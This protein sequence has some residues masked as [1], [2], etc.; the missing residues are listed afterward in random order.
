MS[1]TNY[2]SKES[3]TKYYKK[4]KPLKYPSE[5]YIMRILRGVYPRLKI[6]TLDI[7]GKKVCDIG[8]GDGRNLL[9]LNEAGLKVY[10][11]EIT[12]EI[13]DVAKQ[14]MK[15]SNIDACLK[16]G[17]NDN[18]PFENEFFDF[19]V[20]WGSCYYMGKNP[21]FEKHLLEYSRVLK[22]GGY[23]IAYIPKKSC[24]LYQN[25]VALDDR[26]CV[27]KDDYYGVRNGEIL[28]M[29]DSEQDI[30]DA[31]SKYFENF[32]FGS[33]EDDCF[34]LNYHYHFVVCQKRRKF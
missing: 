29:F 11:I 23:F 8:C 15:E 12:Q 3:W 7:K 20:S 5:Y 30:M 10:G 19:L 9:L 25:S 24:H 21:D 28:R 13:M 17:T 2:N 16:V 27:V 32:V 4:Q 33:S 34:G 1:H 26:Y 18:I 22:E 6:G 31:F 14:R